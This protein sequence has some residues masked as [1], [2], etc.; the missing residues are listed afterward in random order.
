[1]SLYTT[2]P[3][4]TLCAEVA[5]LQIVLPEPYPARVVASR[6]EPIT[7]PAS[8]SRPAPRALLGLVSGGGSPVKTRTTETRS[9]EPRYAPAPVVAE[10]HGAPR[11]FGEVAVAG[12]GDA[13]ATCSATSIAE[14]PVI[15]SRWP[16]LNRRPTVYETV[17]L[18]LSYSGGLGAVTGTRDRRIVQVGKPRR[19]GNQGLRRWWG[20]LSPPRDDAAGA[21][22][23]GGPGRLRRR[24]PGGR[25]RG[26]S[27][28]RG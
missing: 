19:R 22:V 25:G 1:M 24:R 5:K 20:R 7:A 2:Y 16:G 28:R 12:P 10:T 4:S 14:I 3:W 15:S 23:S 9:M 11:S 21:A 18:P 17:A 26:W 13:R 6:A 27:R 8:P